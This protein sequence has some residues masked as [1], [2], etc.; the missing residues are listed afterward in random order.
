LQVETL[1]DLLAIPPGRE[2]RKYLHDDISVVVIRLP[3][4]EAV[5]AGQA[6][7]MSAEKRPSKWDVVRKAIGEYQ[8]INDSKRY[9]MKKWGNVLD[10]VLRDMK[11]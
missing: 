8:K 2:G 9:I 4:A 3:P 7:P 6:I 5:A 1:Q 11:N 10:E